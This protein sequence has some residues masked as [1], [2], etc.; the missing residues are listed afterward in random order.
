MFTPTP[1]LRLLAATAA[2]ALLPALPATAQ[3]TI[4]VRGVG[5]GVITGLSSDG[6][7]AVGQLSGSFE[8]FR[9]TL[10]GG[11][12]LL[13]R[14]TWTTL[15]QGSGTPEISADGQVIG[16]T[17][18]GDDGRSATAGRWTPATGWQP[19]RPLP[20]DV[21]VLDR[22]DSSVHGMSRDGQVFTGL[23]W[24]LG[25]PGGLAHGMTWTADAGMRDQGSS[26]ASSRIDD[27]D[28]TGRVLAGW[29]EDPR[30]GQRR[31]TVWVDG[32]RTLLDDSEFPTEA[33]AVNGDGTILV[34][35]APDPERG[36]Q[37]AAVM[38]R[39]NGATWDRTVLG[40]MRRSGAV[41]GTAYARGV[42]DDGR[43]VVGTARLD[44]SRPGTVGFI[45][46]PETGM[47]K[48]SDWLKSLGIDLERPR[49]GVRFRIA[50]LPAVTPDGRVIAVVLQ[51]IGSVRTR[52]V[53]IQRHPAPVAR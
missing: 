22:E 27:A 52:S 17:I 30:T 53:L 37:Q 23:Y 18:L 35:Q 40:V 13:G 11:R 48:A 29:D 6:R 25:S 2:L 50:D 44:E 38:W 4:T 36:Y 12:E 41:R 33:S 34:G 26:G 3:E 49:P 16:A 19:L 47:M 15:G 45:W 39:F 28:T 46:M 14:S 31:A 42:S 32:V 9:W 7:A 5:S 51:E 43:V 24:R 1:I 10:N 21:G 8:T 20:A